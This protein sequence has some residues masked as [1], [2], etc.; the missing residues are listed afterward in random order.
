MLVLTRKAN[1]SIV[2]NGDITLTVVEVRGNRV[3]LGIVAPQ[4]IPVM[5]R[6]IAGAADDR[7]TA[8][9]APRLALAGVGG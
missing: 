2:I 9:R 1:E 8:R 5:R 4:E 7:P 6:E 3:K